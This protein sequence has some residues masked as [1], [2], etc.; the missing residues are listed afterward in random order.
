[1]MPRESETASRPLRFPGVSF[2]RLSS[3]RK[4]A[5]PIWQQGQ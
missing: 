3:T 1:M 2:I 4:L 5:G